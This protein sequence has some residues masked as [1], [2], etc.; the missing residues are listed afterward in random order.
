MGR[1]KRRQ[2][3][4]TRS[5]ILR[6]HQHPEK[7]RQEPTKV[8]CPSRLAPEGI[9]LARVDKTETMDSPVSPLAHAMVVSNTRG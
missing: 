3:R 5:E 4:V 6:R 1:R 8:L 9:N 2:P 7:M